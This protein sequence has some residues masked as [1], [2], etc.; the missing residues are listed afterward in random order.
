L[1]KFLDQFCCKGGQCA[2]ELC[3]AE[4]FAKCFA[5]TEKER[6]P[7]AEAICD[8]ALENF[9]EMR[10]KTGDVRFQALKKVENKLEN[11]YPEKIRSRYAMVCYGGEGNVSYANAKHLGVVQWQ[12]LEDLCASF[13]DEQALGRAAD[14]VDLEK[15]KALLDE[16]LVPLHAK[17]GIDLATVRH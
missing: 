14:E 2:A 17:L 15:A 9:V 5:A 12:I 10:D 7:N 16:R 3:T 1:S 11:T 8:M 4:N 6:K 13:A